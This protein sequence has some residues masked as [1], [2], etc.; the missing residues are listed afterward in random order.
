MHSSRRPTNNY[1][2]ELLWSSMIWI[3]QLVLKKC[4]HPG[5]PVRIFKV[6]VNGLLRIQHNL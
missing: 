1:D 6:L 2:Q 5:M 4:A 3:L